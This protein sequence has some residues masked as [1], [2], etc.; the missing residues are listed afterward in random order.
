MSG[1]IYWFFKNYNIWDTWCLGA[2]VCGCNIG[3]WWDLEGSWL[4]TFRKFLN[5]FQG[6]LDW[7]H[8]SG[9]YCSCCT[10]VQHFDSHM[11][12]FISQIWDLQCDFSVA[13]LYGGPTLSSH[14]LSPSFISYSFWSHLQLIV[15][16]NQFV[17]HNFLTHT[18]F[19]PSSWP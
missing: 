10:S 7:L 4:E 11:I 17:Y 13:Y 12:T 19:F 16:S 6:P 18:P 3:E 5:A 1:E 9:F 15:K 14:W 8:F 2:G